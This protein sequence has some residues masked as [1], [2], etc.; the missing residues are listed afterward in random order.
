MSLASV[1]YPS[2]TQSGWKEWSFANFQ[3]HLAI[4]K[5]LLQVKGYSY[6]PL[7]LWPVDENDFRDFLQQH[8]QSHNVF[9]DV[10]GIAGRDL[11][12]LD[13]KNKDHRD[14]WFFEHYIQHQAAAQILG[15]TIL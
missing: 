8:Q 7:R 5:G 2:P 14:S 3:H 11:S 4:D 6:N 9:N 12:Q 1:L 13:L 15:L 10:L